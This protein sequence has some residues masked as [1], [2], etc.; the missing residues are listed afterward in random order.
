MI[1]DYS[2]KNPEYKINMDDIFPIKIDANSKEVT[3]KNGK[4]MFFIFSKDSKADVCDA[5]ER[6]MDDRTKSIRVQNKIATLQNN[7]D[8]EEDRNSFIIDCGGNDSDFIKM[9]NLVNRKIETW[10]YDLTL[11]LNTL[12]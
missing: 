4:C 2:E 7:I 8:F 10:T 5:C 9:I 6:Y 12:L 3:N 11:I 1:S